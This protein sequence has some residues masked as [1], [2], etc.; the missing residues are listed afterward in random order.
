MRQCCISFIY[1][2]GKDLVTLAVGRHREH[3]QPG[4]PGRRH[5]QSSEAA[6]LL[7][8]QGS[9]NVGRFF[10]VLVDP[11]AA[12]QLQR[13]RTAGNDL[14]VVLMSRGVQVWRPAGERPPEA[15]Q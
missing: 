12:H 14:E 9:P 4:R 5:V 13:D 11:A 1:P 7:R 6:G 10:G 8:V 15:R 2:G 3:R